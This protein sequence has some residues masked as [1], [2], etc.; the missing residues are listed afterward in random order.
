LNP[1]DPRKK[2]VEKKSKVALDLENLY[3]KLQKN[4]EAS[5]QRSL[6]K[7][8]EQDESEAK[9]KKREGS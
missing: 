8:S 4:K 7:V 2:S 1:Y 5:L 3:N 9:D 6:S